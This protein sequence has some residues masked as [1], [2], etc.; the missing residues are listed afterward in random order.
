MTAAA[1]DSAAIQAHMPMVE[2]KA[3]KLH[4]RLPASVVLDDLVQAGR[5]AVWRALE[6]FDGR[7]NLG[8]HVTKR[9]GFAL[10][11]YLRETHPAGRNGP[12]V[13]HV[14]DDEL[15]LLVAE[16]DPAADVQRAQDFDVQMDKFTPERRAAIQRTL[17]GK[18]GG[19]VS[20]AKVT[21]LLE[22]KKAAAP[23]NYDPQA[24][25]IRMGVVVPPNAGAFK[26][27]NRAA[28]LLA[29]MPAG[30]S[31]LL[32][33]AAANTLVKTMRAA[34]VRYATHKRSETL[35]EVWREPT[36]E[37]LNQRGKHV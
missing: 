14:S 22:G 32:T 4:A 1:V 11:D 28:L 10:I 25:P 8:A 36:A 37:Q 35:T 3:R 26:R 21:A 29:R 15:A 23:S 7:G 5:V 27:P 34:K 30:G 17:A 9:V 24:V 12:A 13:V 2:R 20:A 19:S 6:S 33:H 16:D 18:P 31:V